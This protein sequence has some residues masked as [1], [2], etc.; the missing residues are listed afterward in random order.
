MTVERI[1]G[2]IDAK[3]MHA[4]NVLPPAALKRAT[5]KHQASLYRIANPDNDQQLKLEDAAR[6]DGELIRAG[7][8]PVFREV[9]D[10]LVAAQAGHT[11]QQR[12]DCQGL[13]Q[14]LLHLGGEL[15]ELQ[16]TANEAMVDG[17]LNKRERATL[18]QEAQDVMDGAQ[19]IRDALEPPYADVADDNNV[20]PM[21]QHRAG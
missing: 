21:Q 19:A 6:I 1:A 8:Q 18:A 20:E 7:E 11:T 10:Q 15:G 13:S 5:G 3:L 16:R 2:S 4:L 12:V 9:F 17:Q 14:S